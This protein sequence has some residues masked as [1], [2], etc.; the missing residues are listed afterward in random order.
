MGPPM[1]QRPTIA[2]LLP[3][4]TWQQVISPQ[5]ALQLEVLGR[6][7][8]VDV[9]DGVA[10]KQA[11]G[12]AD[13]ALTGWR[14]PRLTAGRLAGAP[15]LRLI[16]HTAGSVK[17]LIDP[18]AWERGIAVTHAAALIADAVAEQCLG[19]ELLCLRQLHRL[20]QGM[21][22]G[23]SW[24]DL[25]AHPGDL[26]RGQRVGLVGAG[27][28]ARKHLAL[29]RPFECD[30]R[31]YDPYL[32]PSAADELG[33]RRVALND[34]FRECK[35]VSNHAPITPETRGLIGATQLGLLQPGA[36][37]VNTARAY[38]VDYAALLEALREGRFV[39]A[40]DVFEREP[41]P[42][43]SPLLTLPN[44]LLTPHSAGHSVQSHLAQGQAMVE[45]IA[46]F[47]AGEPLRYAV[48]REQLEVMA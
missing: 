23:A 45:E 12:A 17:G 7:L 9:S 43:D 39:A 11:L 40:L 18:V 41:L 46:R 8:R 22:A 28:V 21:R 36:V 2:V 34:L 10:V 30:V 14:S 26:L 27:Y 13:V 42:A 48:S 32:S 35:V 29:L 1:T 24:G 38:T 33:V 47:V 19:A 31:V 6:P 5:A 37:F 20:D 4:E 3:E 25:R 15:G 16:A 44:V